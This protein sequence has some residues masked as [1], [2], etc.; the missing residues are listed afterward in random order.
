MSWVQSTLGEVADIFSGYAFKSA[1]MN[2]EGGTPLIKI[3]N[4]ADSAV[5]HQCDA[6]LNKD[7]NL[8][9]FERFHLLRDDFLVAMTGQGSV[10]RIGKMRDYKPGFYV[11]QRVAI[12]RV[13][14]EKANPVFI[15]YQIA[16]RSN[17]LE[18]FKKANGAG[19]PNISAK[20]IGELPV[21]LPS[22]EQQQYIADVLS[23]YDDLIENNQ[24][25]IKLLEEAAQRLYKEWFVDL[26]FPGHKTT[27]ITD[28][29]PEGWSQ[30]VLGDVVV[31]SGRKISKDNREGYSYYLPIDCLPKKSLG[32]IATNE[33]ALAESSLVAFAPRDII[34]GAMRPYFHK[35]V[36]ARDSGITRTTCFVLNTGNPAYWAYAVMLMF[37]SDTVDYATQISVGTTM[38]YTRWKDF[39]SMPIIVPSEECAIVFGKEIYPIITKIN[40]LAKQIVLLQQARDRLLPK[41]MNGEIEV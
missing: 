24:K 27:P 8:A 41:L 28:G 18:L 39:K 38:P 10:G 36:V 19:Q 13:N 33:I 29:I 3:K 32:Y 16:T 31:E 40:G 35:V 1:D 30:G 25:Q 20:Q 9:K 7:F 26:R 17:E 34:F 2:S 5:S 4:I 15:F 22:T 23:S 14:P 37:S 12:V 21:V 11:N 6:F